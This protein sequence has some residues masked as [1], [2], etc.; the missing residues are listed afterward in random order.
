M[1][2][3]DILKFVAALALVLSLI[4][5]CA[6]LATRLNLLANFNRRMK[7]VPRLSVRET[8]IIDAKHKLMIVA[9]G[10]REH[11]LLF[12]PSG[13]VLIETRASSE[14]GAETAAT[15]T[16]GEM[17]LAESDAQP[18]ES[19]TIISMVKESGL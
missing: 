9:N 19:E 10:T 1:A 11:T 15:P 18:L 12:G 16:E 17:S 14:V 2:F 6:W 5:G 8:L 13:D 4:G 3:L 7:E